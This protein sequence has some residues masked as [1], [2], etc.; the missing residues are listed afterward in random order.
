ML[1][2]TVSE[3]SDAEGKSDTISEN[4][5]QLETKEN[6]KTDNA[7]TNPK[8]PTILTDKKKRL[9]EICRKAREIKE[10][11]LQEKQQRRQ[12][13]KEARE[14]RKKLEHE[15]KKAELRRKQEK[16]EEKRLAELEEK[17]EVKRKRREAKEEEQRR[18]ND[19]RKRKEQEKEEAELKKR[20]AAEA[21]TKFFVNKATSSS[22]KTRSIEDSEDLT[23]AFRP[24][25]VKDDMRIAPISRVH[26]TEVRHRQL[27]EYL[28]PNENSKSSPPLYLEEMRSG[29]IIPGASI[30]PVSDNES[31]DDDM[32]IVGK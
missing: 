16:R 30:H 28:V 10:L 12:R 8:K 31:E 5:A 32:I 6:I 20:R 14:L 22:R 13:E 24:F 4:D 7:K 18:K 17:S 21:F 25:Q 3:S 27:D 1:S 11:E 15:Q 2:T 26:F 19:E 9:S 29:Q 23:L